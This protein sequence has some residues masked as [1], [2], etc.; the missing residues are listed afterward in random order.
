[1]RL[2]YV[3]GVWA[4]SSIRHVSSA[5]GAQIASKKLE[6]EHGHDAGR[7]PDIGRSFSGRRCAGA[8]GLSMTHATAPGQRS[9]HVSSERYGQPPASGRRRPENRCLKA[10][11]GT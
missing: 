7:E 11:T 4:T 5:S 1:M 9:V 2:P 6:A 3:F 8:P 10:G